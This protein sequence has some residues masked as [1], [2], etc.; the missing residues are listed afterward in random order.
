M[1]T[2]QGYFIRDSIM[3][4]EVFVNKEDIT[5]VSEYEEDA[6]G[7]LQTKDKKLL[8]DRHTITIL[9]NT[10]T[11]NNIF[12]LIKEK[13]DCYTLI[14]LP[15]TTR[16]IYKGKEIRDEIFNF[17]G[18]GCTKIGLPEGGFQ[19]VK[20]HFSKSRL[21]SHNQTIN[22]PS[23]LENFDFSLRELMVPVEFLINAK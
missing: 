1:E 6:K 20:S 8:A 23:P 9:R 22:V 17:Q 18:K 13:I 5:E 21:H 3:D 4:T 14:H 2:D 16:I 10:E 12:D 19:R 7:K 11:T 15:P